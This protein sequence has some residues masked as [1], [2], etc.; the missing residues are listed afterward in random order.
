MMFQQKQDEF[1]IFSWSVR[2][3]GLTFWFSKE[4]R[5]GILW[6]K[7]IL[8]VCDFLKGTFLLEN[9]FSLEMPPDAF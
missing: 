2:T 7:E 3:S 6:R 1:L 5:C 8:K 9:E 4:R